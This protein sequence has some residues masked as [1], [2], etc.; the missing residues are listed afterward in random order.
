MRMAYILRQ[1]VADKPAPTFGYPT[2][3]AAREIVHKQALLQAVDW[4]RDE[5]GD[6]RTRVLLC[7]I[8]ATLL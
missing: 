2:S 1:A 5:I 8:V 6:T 4:L 3:S 7:Q